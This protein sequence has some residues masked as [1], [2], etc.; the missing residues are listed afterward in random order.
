MSVTRRSGNEKG[1]VLVLMVLAMTVVF[2]VGAIA[3]DI[4]LWLSER[5][6]SQTDADF[7]A[8]AGAWELLDP[9]ATVAEV[10][11]AVDH[12]L[13]AND[14]E[15]NLTLQNPPVVDL[16]ARCVS[17]DV[18]HDSSVVFFSIFGLLEPEI[19]AHAKA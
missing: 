17:V 10:N 15:L 16:A 6:G 11:T 3:V 14:G 12:S 2:V 4:G 8:L 9:A 7:L 1:Q 13:L 19:G 18:D 5:R